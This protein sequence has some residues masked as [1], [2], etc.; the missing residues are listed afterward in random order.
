MR[1]IDNLLGQYAESHQNSFNKSIHYVCVPAIFWTVVALLWCIKLPFELFSI[2]ANVAMFALA[3]VWLYYVNLSIT[4]SIGMLL[5]S[6]ICFVLCQAIEGATSVGSLA[7]IAAVTFVVAWIFQFYG[8]K[9]EG[10][11]PSFLKDLQF[12]LIGPAWIM[13]YIYKNVG[14][15]L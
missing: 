5:Y 3:A 2:K 14:I 1:A 12:L 4:L 6:A 11:K 15:K 13:S 7:I 9:V 8:H 10:K